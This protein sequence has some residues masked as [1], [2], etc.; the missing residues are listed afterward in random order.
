MSQIR[1]KITL[2]ALLVL[3]LLLVTS[4]NIPAFFMLLAAFALHE[5]AHLLTG[6][7]LG[8]PDGEFQL[9]PFG[10]K[11][12]LNPLF[13]MNAEAEWFIALSGPLV[14][15]L[16]VGGVCYLNWLGFQNQYLAYWQKINFLLGTVNLIP[17]LPLD[18]GRIVHA[19]LNRYLGMNKAAL[20]SKVIA[21][22]VAFLLLGCG[23]VSFIS[24][25]G[26][27][28]FIIIAL[29]IGVHWW[30]IRT[31]AM[32]LTWKLLQH[33]KER[34]QT[35]GLLNARNIMVTPETLLKDALQEYGTN[36]YLL[37]YLFDASQ[38]FWLVSEDLAWKSLVVHGFN[39][40]FLE[41]IKAGFTVN[42]QK[43]NR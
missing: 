20:A 43:V 19:W 39:T 22:T 24:G 37:F 34:L 36:D 25:R 2:P 4:G 18:G 41:T 9:T 38:N 8:Y 13:A 10:G 17:A 5:S 7:L 29:V 28:L 26:G 40:T 32:N 21:L 30:H 6:D 33:K 11:V 42:L 3:G 1:L 31:P 35:Y 12:N 15:W 16:M 23:V 27:S 14:N